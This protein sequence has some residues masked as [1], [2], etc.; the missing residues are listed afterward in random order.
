MLKREVPF[1]STWSVIWVCDLGD[2][3][4]I[5]PHAAQKKDLGFVA[6]CHK[7]LSPKIPLFFSFNQYTRKRQQ[8][9][10][11]QSA[12]FWQLIGWG[13][14]DGTKSPNIPVLLHF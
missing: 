11:Q 3:S 7:T 8:T 4:I 10:C 12:K 5:N 2:I 6:G 14:I 1:M 9:Q 13:Y